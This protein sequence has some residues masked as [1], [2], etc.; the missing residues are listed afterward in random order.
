MTNT[1]TYIHRISM[2]LDYSV[3][4]NA[5]RTHDVVKMY[6]LRVGHG[7][8]DRKYKFDVLFLAVFNCSTTGNCQ[9]FD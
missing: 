2:G 3:C 8:F 5:F 1:Y 7:W 4:M 6:L 9:S